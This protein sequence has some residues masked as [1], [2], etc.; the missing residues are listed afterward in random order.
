MSIASER[1]GSVLVVDLAKARYEFAR[2]ATDVPQT[3]RHRLAPRVR[4]VGAVRVVDR[5]THYDARGVVDCVA[6]GDDGDV[7]LTVRLVS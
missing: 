3:L 6:V 4:A 1:D 7:D 5:R 2:R